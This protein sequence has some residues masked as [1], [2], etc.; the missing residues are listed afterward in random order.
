MYK[1]HIFHIILEIMDTTDTARSASFLDLN[2]AID[3]EGRLKLKL[4]D[5]WDYLSFPI[6]N[7]PFICS[8]IPAAPALEAY[9]SLSWYNIQGLWFL[10]WYPS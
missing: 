2:I 5:K 4:Y 1:I 8:N 9:I 7:V 3:S 10:S 6:V